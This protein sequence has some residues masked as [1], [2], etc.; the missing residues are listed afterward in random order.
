[1]TQGRAAVVPSFARTGTCPVEERE[2]WW[3]VAVVNAVAEDA[4]H[5]HSE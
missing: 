4:S 5:L 1:M 2:R 3:D